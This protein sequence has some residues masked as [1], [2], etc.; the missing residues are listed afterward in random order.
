MDRRSLAVGFAVA[1]SYGALT[2]PAARAGATIPSPSGTLVCPT[3]DEGTIMPPLPAFTQSARISKV[4]VHGAESPCDHSAATGGRHPIDLALVTWTG[5]LPRGSSCETEF[6]EP[7]VEGQP[8]PTTLD[9]GMI[10]VRWLALVV[11]PTGRHS[12]RLIGTTSVPI[13]SV[14]IV[15]DPSYALRIKSAPISRGPFLGEVITLHEIFASFS[16]LFSECTSP[17]GR[18]S[19]LDFGE[20]EPSTLTVAP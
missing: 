17:S 8:V 4:K 3:T 10:H 18:V 5:R 7:P 13:A 2:A 12:L 1:V 14:E 19:R 9:M 6:S 16:E 11:G 20:G 15:E